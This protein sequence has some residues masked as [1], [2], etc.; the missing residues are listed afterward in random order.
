MKSYSVT[1]MGADAWQTQGGRRA[2]GPPGQRSLP[3]VSP[4]Q[5]LPHP[6]S[7]LPAPRGAVWADQVGTTPLLFLGLSQLRQEWQR[8]TWHACVPT[9]V[10][11][12]VLVCVEHMTRN[13]GGC[14]LEMP[15]CHVA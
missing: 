11:T 1:C 3:S 4:G 14:S 8:R 10:C 9:R 6:G 2:S 5:A 7:S 15:S 12:C 13:L